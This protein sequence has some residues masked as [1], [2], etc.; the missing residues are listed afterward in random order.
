VMSRLHRGR[1]AMQK[2]L[3]DFA[4]EQGMLAR[5]PSIETEDP[6]DG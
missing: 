5:T 1:K 6:A 3:A 4:T 2:A